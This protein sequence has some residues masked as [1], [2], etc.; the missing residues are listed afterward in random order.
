MIRSVKII[1]VHCFIIK[2]SS[3]HW[4]N[5]NF[6]LSSA[7]ISMRFTQLCYAHSQV[8]C[9]GYYACCW[10]LM[11]TGL[12]PFII[13]SRKLTVEEAR[14][15]LPQKVSDQP[16]TTKPRIRLL[17]SPCEVCGEQSGTGT[18]SSQ[19]TSGFPCHYHSINLHSP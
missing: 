2:D 8:T 7:N 5:L 16:L 12:D 1:L 9:H 15:F 10:S 17:T 6:K 3:L 14:I 4:I 13:K 19:S 11:K 18:G